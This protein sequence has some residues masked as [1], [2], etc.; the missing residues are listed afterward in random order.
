MRSSFWSFRCSKVCRVHACSAFF[1]FF[2]PLQGA[3]PKELRNPKNQCR[4]FP[5]FESGDTIATLAGTQRRRKSFSRIK[6]RSH[7]AIA[8]PDH[9][10]YPFISHS[11]R[12]M[13]YDVNIYI[14]KKKKFLSVSCCFARWCWAEERTRFRR[15]GK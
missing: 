5:S 2:A 3:H 1:F 10:Q 14:K 4:L 6:R 15:G 12:F 13:K 8:V 11:S 9:A 7:F